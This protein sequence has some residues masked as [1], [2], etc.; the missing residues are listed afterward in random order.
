MTKRTTHDLVQMAAH[1]TQSLYELEPEEDIGP[2]LGTTI[3][4]YMA[5]T[6]AKLEALHHVLKRMAAEQSLLKQETERLATRRKAIA[7]GEAQV[8]ALSLDLLEAHED[9]TGDTFVTTTTFSAKLVQNPG[10]VE[11]SID[12]K[13]L[14]PLF[15]IEQRVFVPVKTKLKA[16]LKQGAIIPGVQLVTS[17]RIKWS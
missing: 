2:V 8:K 1:I 12:A 10:R 4:E 11:I 17:R 9:L 14:D 5:E 13:E 7:R 3:M 6:P 16:A 15:T